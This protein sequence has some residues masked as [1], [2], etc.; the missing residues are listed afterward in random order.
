MVKKMNSLVILS[1]TVCYGQNMSLHSLIKCCTS[2]NTSNNTYVRQAIALWRS[3]N[4]LWSK[5]DTYNVQRQDRA[6]YYWY[7]TK[8]QIS[9]FVI[10]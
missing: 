7:K 9:N 2:S 6:G 1:T 8:S 3:K 5:E 10:L 4:T